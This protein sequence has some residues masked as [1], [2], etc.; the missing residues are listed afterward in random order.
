M[1][2]KAMLM[3][4]VI[5]MNLA[6]VLYSYAVF[7]GRKRGL[8]L[9]EMIVFGAGL[10]FDYLGTMQMGHYAAIFGKAP[11]W[12]NITGVSSLYGMAFHFALAL[13]ATLLGRA[14]VVDRIFHRVSLTIYLLWVA[15]FLSGAI[16]GVLRVAGH[17]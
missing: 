4:A 1:T 13:I 11:Q 7:S 5:P 2:Q 10:C 9:R 12:H 6:L 8:H 15:A 17:A 14:D 3:Q 16:A